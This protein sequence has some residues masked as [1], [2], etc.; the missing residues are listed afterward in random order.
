M[1]PC[2]RQQV[3]GVADIAP[4]RRDFVAL[5]AA[6]ALIA[7]A[8][9]VQEVV[10]PSRAV[11]VIAVSRRGADRHHCPPGGL[12]ADGLFQPGVLCR[13]RQRGERRSRRRDGRAGAPADGY[14]LM[15]VTRDMPIAAVMPSKVG[16]DRIRNFAPVSIIS[17]SPS[18]LLLHP[19]VPAKTVAE[20]ATLARR[21]LHLGQLKKTIDM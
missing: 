11:R 10:Y 20:C 12:D 21:D 4:R 13:E 9:H 18:G 16:Y 17:R 3:N 7:G 2:S 14:T 5:L 1:A 15:V 6:L 8:G 19:S